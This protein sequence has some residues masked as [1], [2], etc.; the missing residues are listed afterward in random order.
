M[1]EVVLGILIFAVIYA[2]L[3]RNPDKI[4]YG[5]GVL[6]ASFVIWILGIGLS[7]CLIRLLGI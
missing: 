4:K 6:Q 5:L 1:F 2:V 3:R 7:W